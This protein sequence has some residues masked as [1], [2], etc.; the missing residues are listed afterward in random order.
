MQEWIISCN[1]KKYD[2]IKAF[3]DLKKIEWTQPF[4]LNSV[5]ST[6]QFSLKI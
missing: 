3:N 6:T 5:C 1:P 2:V 4:Q